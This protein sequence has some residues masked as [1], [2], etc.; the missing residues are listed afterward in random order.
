MNQVVHRD[1]QSAL[2]DHHRLR[3]CSATEG[4]LLNAAT[5][6]DLAYLDVYTN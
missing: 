6:T 5:C 1:R 3:E 4:G 2:I